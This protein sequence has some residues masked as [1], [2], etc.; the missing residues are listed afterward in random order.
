MWCGDQK[1]KQMKILNFKTQVNKRALKE[2]YYVPWGS[3]KQDREI[4]LKPSGGQSM[5]SWKSKGVGQYI[6]QITK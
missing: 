3:Q 5:H 4:F 1:I 2:E 6:A